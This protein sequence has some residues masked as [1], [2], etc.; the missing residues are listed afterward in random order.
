MTATHSLN[1]IVRFIDDE[2]AFL[3]DKWERIA[4]WKGKKFNEG[5][6]VGDAIDIEYK[7]AY[8]HHLRKIAISRPL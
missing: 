1:P 7:A 6:T 5:Y 8:L 4:D 3:K 2:L